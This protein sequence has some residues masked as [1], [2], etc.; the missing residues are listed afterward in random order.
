MEFFNGV[1]RA[2]LL[3]IPLAFYFL[4]NIDF[5]LPHTTHFDNNII[6]P[7]L[8]FASLGFM[9]SVFFTL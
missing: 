4:I 3:N 8:V 9:F 2:K 1:L 5:L 6:L 7:V